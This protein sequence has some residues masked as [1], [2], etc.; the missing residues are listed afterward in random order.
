MHK[1]LVLFI[2][3]ATLASS[4]AAQ[5]DRPTTRQE[6]TRRCTNDKTS[7]NTVKM[8]HDGIMKTL[9][10]KKRAETDP[11]KLKQLVQDEERELERYEDDHEKMCRTICQHN[12]E[13]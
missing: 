11:D 2:A 3:A 5:F 12:P 1:H 10:E 9:G 7:T 6:C 13:N 8:R 4:A